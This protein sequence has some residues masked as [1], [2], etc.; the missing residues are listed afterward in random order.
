[1]TGAAVSPPPGTDPRRTF[2]RS[3]GELVA[4][5]RA[6]PHDTRAQG[7]ALKSATLSLAVVPVTVDAALHH[8]EVGQV[9]LPGQ[10]L[11]RGVARIA[12]LAGAPASE[13]LAAARAL[14]ATEGPVPSSAHVLVE[15]V[16]DLGVQ[17]T[18]Y[19]GPRERADDGTTFEP[20]R[21]GGDRRSW[22]DRRRPP[23]EPWTGTE[24]RSG[25]DRRGRGERRVERVRAL[26]E[27]VAQNRRRLETACAGRQWDAALDAALALVEALPRIPAD[28]RRATRTA[29][30]QVL[31][32]PVVEAMADAGLRD[33]VLQPLAAMVLPYAGTLGLEVL[34]DRVCQ[35]GSADA[36]A[37]Y[38]DA[39]VLAPETVNLALAALASPH[40]HTASQAATL[41]ARVRRSRQAFDALVRQ[42]DH[43]DPR[44]RAAVAD[45]LASYPPDE[46]APVLG[47]ALRRGDRELRLVL[48]HV[49]G[50]RRLRGLVGVLDEQLQRED[51]DEVWAACVRALGAIPSAE[52]CAALMQVV[53]RRRSL[54][55]RD[56][57]A[58]AQRLEALEALGRCEARGVVTALRR[59]ARDGDRR[60]RERAAALLAARE[61]RDDR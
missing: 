2:V 3:F 15:P 53:L 26:L 46:M 43:P 49:A 28:E 52:A 61:V 40:A 37:A 9:H 4:L 33:P 25:H 27:R 24:R 29:L 6:R 34:F 23:R 18:D 7:E 50:A 38:A 58:T 19:R 47:R 10:M 51:D 13:L 48:A 57:F 39:L 59:I 45:A 5:L 55:R 54:L 36:V 42:L 44:V 22:R 20:V 60:V 31:V 21:S 30:R 11:L 35:V 17:V 41:I 56:G 14:A 12:F 32:R 8:N 16:D 1:M